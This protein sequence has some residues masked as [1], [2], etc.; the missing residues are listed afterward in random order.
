MRKRIERL[1]DKAGFY[2]SRFV[3][4]SII[5]FGGLGVWVVIVLLASRSGHGWIAYAAL[6]ILFFGQVYLQVRWWDI[7]RSTNNVAPQ[8]AGATDPE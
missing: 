2:D 4:F 7:A 5:G 3:R 6:P 8:P 1:L